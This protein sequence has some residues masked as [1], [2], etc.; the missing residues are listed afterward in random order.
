MER[1]LHARKRRWVGLVLDHFLPEGIRD[2][3]SFC[4]TQSLVVLGFHFLSLIAKPRIESAFV[5]KQSIFCSRKLNTSNWCLQAHH[6]RDWALEKRRVKKM[7]KVEN[8][9]FDVNTIDVSI[10]NDN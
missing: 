7:D 10:S 5:V 2:I 6:E 4:G 9:C 8:K 3:F 1:F